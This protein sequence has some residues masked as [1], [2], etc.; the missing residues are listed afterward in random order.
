MMQQANA[1]WADSCQQVLGQ[2]QHQWQLEL[3]LLNRR[4][5]LW[6]GEVM[7]TLAAG[8]KSWQRV[9]EQLNKEYN[10]WRRNFQQELE[11]RQ[12]EWDVNYLDFLQ[13]KEAWIQESHREGVVQGL[14]QDMMS[15]SS[16][17]SAINQ[18]E[19]ESQLAQLGRNMESSVSQE[20]TESVVES[21]LADSYLDQLMN[22]SLVMVGL[23]SNA[24]AGIKKIR[25]NTASLESHLAAQ[26]QVAKTSQLMKDVAGRQAV[27]YGQNLLEQLLTSYM[28]GI[29]SQNKFMVDW[30]ETL[31][32]DAGYTVDGSIRRTIVVDATLWYEPQ[33]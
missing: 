20:M 25:R 31:A 32:R 11:E 28:E 26:E 6:E 4:Q 22:R 17:V 1:S 9:E 33:F 15:G 10:L 23:G 5:S 12:S 7:A 30:Q 29:A 21:L 24:G 8:E 19:L 18:N 2:A 16:L 3:D 27:D 13:K 14:G